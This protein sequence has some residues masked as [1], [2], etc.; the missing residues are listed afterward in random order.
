MVT[1]CVDYPAIISFRAQLY[2]EDRNIVL[3]PPTPESQLLFELVENSKADAFKYVAV[4]PGKH[5]ESKTF[6]VEWWNAVLKHL[7]DA[8]FTPVLIGKKDNMHG[9]GYVDVD[10]TGCVDLLDHTTIMESVWLL[11]QLPM[12][13]CSDSSPLHMAVSGNAFIA[14]LA[15]AKHPD[16]ITHWRRNLAGVNEWSWRM[17][18]FSKGGIWDIIGHLPDEMED[19][20]VDK[21]TESVLRGWLPDPEVFVPWAKESYAAYHRSI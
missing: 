7:I 3:K 2:V 20:S 13:I 21:V 8:G 14:Y 9:G 4:H 1:N 5:W 19:K 10:R 12:L 16:Y 18:N 15:T 17:K 11:Q 6:P